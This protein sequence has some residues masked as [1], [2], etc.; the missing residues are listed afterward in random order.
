VLVEQVASA[1]SA[2][3]LNISFGSGSAEPGPI[4]IGL[5]RRLFSFGA[6]PESLQVNYLPHAFLHHAINW[7][8]K[9]FHK[10]LE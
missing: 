1:L 4:G 5:L 6:F 10:S 3:F 9:E 7:G 8:L 2:L